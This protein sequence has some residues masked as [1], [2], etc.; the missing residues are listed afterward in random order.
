MISGLV[1]LLSTFAAGAGVW[2]LTKWIEDAPV[3][4]DPWSAEIEREINQPDAVE[5][6]HR[7][8]T[9]QSPTAWFCP[10]CGSAVGPYNNL[11]PYLNAFSEGEVF[12]NG[13]TDRMR[14]NAVTIA[15]YFLYSLGSY[16]IFAPI[17]WVYL[18]RNL[19]SQDDKPI[20]NSPAV[21]P[22]S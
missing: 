17:F 20:E 21:E 11:M 16:L 19:R 4:P 13:V 12:R 7:C 22:K 14:K 6:C 2:R 3:K 1:T 8:G 15:G 9:P 18:F 10:Y 5:V